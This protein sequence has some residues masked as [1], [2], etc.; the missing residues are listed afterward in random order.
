MTRTLILPM[1]A[2]GFALALV[3]CN[4]GNDQDND[5]VNAAQ[6]AAAGPVGATS[7][8]TLGANTVDA[9]VSNAAE[10]DMYEIRAAEIALDRSQNADVR[11][12]AEMIRD[13]HR[14][15]SEA[16]AP[17][18]RDAGQ[19][20]PTE[21]DE[22]RQGLL[23]N[24]S[25]ADLNQFDRVW[26]EQQVAAHNEALILH[27]GFSDDEDHAQLASHARSVVEPIRRHLERAEALLEAAE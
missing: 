6:D 16:M 3:G 11:A 2:V 25:G 17:L 4:P 20:I 13:D 18:A 5:A 23:D 9:Y 7:A 15:A 26:L 14:A 22:R 21:L 19:A 27:E 8:A 10:G 12:L 24:L 1:S